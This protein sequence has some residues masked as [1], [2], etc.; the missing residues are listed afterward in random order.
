MDRV[1][2]V[3]VGAAVSGLLVLAALT[4]LFVLSLFL[5]LQ[6]GAHTQIASATV[7]QLVAL[8]NTHV[9][10]VVGIGNVCILI[11]QSRKFPRRNIWEHHR[12][13]QVDDAHAAVLV[14]VGSTRHAVVLRA[15]ATV[16]SAASGVVAPVAAIA[17]PTGEDT[18]VTA[19][20]RESRRLAHCRIDIVTI[21]VHSVASA[22]GTSRR[23][24]RQ[25][26]V[27]GQQNRLALCGMMGHQL[28]GM[29]IGGV[30]E[31][32]CSS[33]K[34]LL[35]DLLMLMLLLDVGRGRTVQTVQAV[36]VTAAAAVVHELVR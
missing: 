36:V 35:Q 1:S 30:Y 2:N 17:R 33:W 9:A 20:A 34:G 29:D 15:E 7:V 3:Q 24:L 28:C 14:Q 16:A 23:A 31:S 10:I 6:D 5:S 22:T 18:L 21:V 11:I 12:G 4:G 27:V 32:A 19:A 26:E 8:E 13:R 25:R